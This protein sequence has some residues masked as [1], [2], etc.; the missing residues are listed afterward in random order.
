MNFCPECNNL[1]YF[2]ENTENLFLK[3]NSCQYT[4][5]Y[6]KNV[7]DEKIYKSQSVYSDDTNE[8]T[9]FDVSLPHTKYKKCPN[10]NCITHK[11]NK[12]VDTVM[13]T[14]KKTL[15][16]LYICCYCKTEWKYS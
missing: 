7:I 16:M 11:E 1:L 6:E 4:I 14:E 13:Y 10:D 5:K 3:C 9:I 2:Q 8:W 15:K 12:E